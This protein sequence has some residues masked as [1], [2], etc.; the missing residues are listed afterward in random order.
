M[1]QATTYRELRK[2]TTDALIAMYDQ[3]ATSR[4]VHVG[5]DFVL[6]EIWRRD[7]EKQTRTM[8][9]LT[10]VIAFLTAVNAVLVALSV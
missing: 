1:T 6:Q 5:L 4:P 9:L 10:W 7:Q 3:I 8:V 2:L